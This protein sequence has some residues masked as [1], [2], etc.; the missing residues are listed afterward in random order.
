MVTVD[1]AKIIELLRQGSFFQD[2]E[3]EALEALCANCQRKVF[4]VGEAL[5]TAGEAGDGAFVLLSGKIE[6]SALV[7]PDGQR[8]EHYSSPGDLVSLSTLVQPWE[9]TSSGTPIER[10]E[11]LELR[12]EK[13]MEMFERDEVAAFRIVD[14]IASNLVEEMR[15]SNRRLHKVFGQ[16]AETL[17]MLRRRMRESEG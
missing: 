14:A 17:R 5:W 13:F 3:D 11:V 2:W 1:Q 10:C 7:R 8:V 6:R 4:N 15:D 16:P 9:H 12:R